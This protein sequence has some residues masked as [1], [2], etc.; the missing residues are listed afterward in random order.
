MKATAPARTPRSW[1]TLSASIVSA[2][3][4]AV[5]YEAVSSTLPSQTRSTARQARVRRPASPTAIAATTAAERGE[6]KPPPGAAGTYSGGPNEVGPA[7]AG[8]MKPGEGACGWWASGRRDSGPGAATP[9]PCRSCQRC[10][11][12]AAWR[13][14]GMSEDGRSGRRSCPQVPHQRLRPVVCPQ[15][16]HAGGV[17]R[18]GIDRGPKRL[19]PPT[20]GTGRTSGGLP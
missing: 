14:S 4:R 19:E 16:G 8:G 15:R 20:R 3:F 18:R 1:M 9:L 2:T 11:R 12:S 10:S 13:A 6:R 17:T 7:P 5:S